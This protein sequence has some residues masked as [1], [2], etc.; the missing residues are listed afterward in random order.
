MYTL[1]FTEDAKKDLKEL[2]KRAP[3]ALAKLSKLLEEVRE[4]PRAGRG[5][6]IFLNVLIFNEL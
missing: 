4:H 3:L 2:S 5:Y 6:A 1:V